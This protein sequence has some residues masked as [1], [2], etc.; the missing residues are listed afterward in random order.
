MILFYIIIREKMPKE[1]QCFFFLH[2]NAGTI[3]LKYRI[4]RDPIFPLVL[5]YT[6]LHDDVDLSPEHNM[7]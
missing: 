3:I 5:H 7:K 4:E 6:I 1:T 2:K